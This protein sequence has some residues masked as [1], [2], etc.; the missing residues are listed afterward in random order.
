VPFG[1]F[2]IFQLWVLLLHFQFEISFTLLFG[3]AFVTPGDSKSA[4]NKTLA[5]TPKD[6]DS[7]DT[8]IKMAILFDIF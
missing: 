6:N 2:M 1:P 8:K 7:S 5:C 4:K 3:T